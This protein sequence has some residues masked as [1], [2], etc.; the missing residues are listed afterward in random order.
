MGPPSNLRTRLRPDGSGALRARDAAVTFAALAGGNPLSVEL[1]SLSG[2]HVLLR[3]GS[4]LA[5]GLALIALDGIAGRIVIVPPDLKPDYLEAVIRRA[6]IDTLVSDGAAVEGL[7]QVAISTDLAPAA[8]NPAPRVSEWV[9]FTSGTT[10]V[11]KMVA[12]TLEALTGAIKPA[13]KGIVWGTFYDIR[14]YGGLQIF[15]RAV[16][17][18]ATL[19][20]SEPDEAIADFLVRLGR[21]GVTHL[22]GTP[23][24][25]RRALMSPMLERIAPRYVRLSG[26]IADQAVLDS[27]K[28]RFPNAAVGHAYASTEAGVGFEVTDGLA[29]FPAAFIGRPGPV[30]MRVVDG[31]LQ[32]RSS[33]TA[34]RFIGSADRLHE[35]GFVDTG[36]MV[37][38]RGDRYYFAGRRGGIINVGGLKIHP[39]EVEAVIN[40]HP[41]VRQSRVLGRRNPITGAI[42]VAEV[43]LA[44]KQAGETIREEI[45]RD[46]RASLKP[47]QVPATVRFVPQLELSAG[48]KLV[49]HA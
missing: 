8:P 3:T 14:R 10:G 42:V 41:A 4:Q 19:I 9:M 23:S 30:D 11:P 35:G 15:L 39:E 29:G 20:L 13:D 36:D 21:D 7:S 37:E 5:V 2:A 32:I 25:W 33:R 16:L 38:L 24:H 1:S 48:G 6:E 31:S 47:F 27:L 49:R 46:C 40:R 43:V 34:T 22:T 45:L 26:E 17:G 44:D 18:D 28:A 12:H